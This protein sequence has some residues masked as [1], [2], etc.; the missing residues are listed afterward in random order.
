MSANKF[1][2]ARRERCCGQPAIGDIGLIYVNADHLADD[3]PALERRAIHVL[4][5]HGMR[6]LAFQ[7]GRRS[8][9]ARRLHNAAGGG[10]K[11]GGFEFTHTFRQR[12]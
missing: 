2:T 8:G 11:P 5:L 12:V 10:G 7:S 3:D 1:V 9:H 6:H 4:Q